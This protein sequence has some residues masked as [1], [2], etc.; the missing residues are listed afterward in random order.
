MAQFSLGLV[1]IFFILFSK[2][3]ADQIKVQFAE[4]GCEFRISVGGKNWLRSGVFRLR[5][6][7][8]WWSSDSSDKNSLRLVDEDD[9]EEGSDS[10]GKFSKHR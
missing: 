1:C 4:D 8:K 6:D 9:K 10:T 2:T 7:G 3:I 5:H